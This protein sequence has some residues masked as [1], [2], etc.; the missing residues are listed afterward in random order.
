V[1]ASGRSETEGKGGKKFSGKLGP[2]WRGRGF[3][4]FSF[5]AHAVERSREEKKKRKTSVSSDAKSSTRTGRRLLRPVAGKREGKGKK[6][7]VST[8]LLPH[9]V[10]PCLQLLQNGAGKGG[11]RGEKKKGALTAVGVG[12]LAPKL[13][14]EE[15]GKKKQ[16][17]QPDRSRGGREEEKKSVL[18]FR[19]AQG[20][21]KRKEKIFPS[22]FF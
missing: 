13:T 12:L 3:F 1:R 21:G 16:C 7:W 17:H 4:S 14:A 22:P 15:R 10:P 18:P 11:E 2:E 6:E 19:S 5:P 8:Q 9:R 20:A